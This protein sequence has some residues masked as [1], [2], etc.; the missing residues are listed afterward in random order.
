MPPVPRSLAE[1]ARDAMRQL[2]RQGGG[3]T[4]PGV[5]C[6]SDIVPLFGRD[7]VMEMLRSQRLPGVQVVTAGVW[8]C[9][10]ETFLEWLQELCHAETTTLGFRR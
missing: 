7:F 2:E 9:S 6:S 1:R 8:R 5:L 3:A 4:L 10:R